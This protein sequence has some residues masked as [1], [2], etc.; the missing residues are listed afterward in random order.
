[1]EMTQRDVALSIWSDLF[2]DVYG[3]RPRIDTSSWSLDDFQAVSREREVKFIIECEMKDRWVPHFLAMLKYMQQLGGMGSSRLV[4]I[5]ADGDGD[6]NP[7]FKWD[8]SLPSDA[9]PTSDSNG[10]RIY[11]A[12]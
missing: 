4:G 12:G 3:S 9:T 7:R 8:E 6:F 1:M 11:D 2:K 5:Y 10:D